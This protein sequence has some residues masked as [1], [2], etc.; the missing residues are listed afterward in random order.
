MDLHAPGP[1]ATRAP[2]ASSKVKQQTAVFGPKTVRITMQPFPS[3]RELV[4]SAMLV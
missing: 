3:S 1:Q 4:G 2:H